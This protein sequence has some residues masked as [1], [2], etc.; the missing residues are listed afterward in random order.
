[1]RPGLNL[2]VCGIVLCYN[3]D[4]QVW[5]QRYACTEQAAGEIKVQK[6][7]VI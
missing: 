2:V 3:G 7:C 1:M 4:L 5:V 6:A